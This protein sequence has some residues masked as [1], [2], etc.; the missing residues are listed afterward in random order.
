MTKSTPETERQASR[1]QGDLFQA[2]SKAMG[3]PTRYAIFQAI[4]ASER[5]L[6]VADLVD[7]FSLNHNTIRQHLAKL[8]AAE[9]VEEV[10]ELPSGP[11]RP[12]RSYRL[13]DDVATGG[14]WNADGP[15]ERLS[16]LLLQAM[17]GSASPYE[18]GHRAGSQL[19]TVPPT[20]TDPIKK[21]IE[22]IGQQGFAPRR[23]GR[24]PRHEIELQTCPFASAAV[25]NPTVVCALHRGMLDGVA[26][27]IDGI[28]V[29]NLAATDPR[30]AHCAVTVAY[31]QADDDA[32]PYGVGHED[33]HA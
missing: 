17:D 11:G 20:G 8:R 5:P 1:T 30:T 25:A 24:G 26:T 12:R 14:R 22:V 13:A 15:Y 9:L 32:S 19:T 29:A 4:A 33:L 28:T 2:R 7:A 27:Q 18:V 6:Q 10:G 31:E 16:L 23:A 21:M 3:D